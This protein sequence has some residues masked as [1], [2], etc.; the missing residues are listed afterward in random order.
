M[1]PYMM[2]RYG[3]RIAFVLSLFVLSFFVIKDVLDSNVEKGQVWIM[4]IKNNPY[5]KEIKDTV[6]V[7]DVCENFAYVKYKGN[8]SIW[9]KYVIQRNRKLLK[10]KE[11]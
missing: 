4:D 6:E 1:E 7:L 11:K 9:E 10:I 8:I 5:N 3:I 2:F